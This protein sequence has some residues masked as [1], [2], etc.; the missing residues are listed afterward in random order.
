MGS[1]SERRW[2]GLK[3]LIKGIWGRGRSGNRSRNR[4]KGNSREAKNICCF[5][6]I[7]Y[8]GICDYNLI[9]ILS[10]CI[11]IQQSYLM[12]KTRLISY[13]HLLYY[14]NN[15]K[16]KGKGGGGFSTIIHLF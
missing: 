8:L 12:Q 7:V 5:L 4:R 10:T 14:K 11:Y 3:R 13:I 9:I 6:I 1:D 15:H 2:C 16:L